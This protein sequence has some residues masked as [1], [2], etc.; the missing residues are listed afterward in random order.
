MIQQQIRE[1]I[2]KQYPFLEQSLVRDLVS[3]IQQNEFYTMREGHVVFRMSPLLQFLK[4]AGPPHPS[5]LFDSK[6]KQLLL[7]HLTNPIPPLTTRRQINEMD[8]LL[9]V[10]AS[11]PPT[12]WNDVFFLIRLA[13]KYRHHLYCLSPDSTTT[14][15]TLTITKD[16]HVLRITPTH[17]YINNK[18]VNLELGTPT[19]RNNARQLLLH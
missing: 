7:L 5:S 9:G 3:I 15:N 1:K 18:E 19:E 11:T 13:Y 10:A 12:R 2:H 6:R 17:T 16:G 4:K 8:V 14:H